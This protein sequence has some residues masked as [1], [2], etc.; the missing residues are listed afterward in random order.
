MDQQTIKPEQVREAWIMIRALENTM[1]YVGDVA[2]GLADA[3]EASRTYNGPMPG[4][5]CPPFKL[6]LDPISE[7][8]DKLGD[9]REQADETFEVLIDLLR[10]AERQGIDSIAF[11]PTQEPS[12]EMAET[13]TKTHPI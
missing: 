1:R 2:L 8:L 3:V 13:E 9:Y 4:P 6:C 11:R 10:K 12:Y 5:I 7:I